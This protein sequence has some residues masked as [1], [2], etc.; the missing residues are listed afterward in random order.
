M[1]RNI[2]ILN[3]KVQLN[4][5][6]IGGMGMMKYMQRL[7]KSL[8]LPV[9]VMP[10]AALLK[11]IGYWI[12]PTGWGSN[13]AIAAF[14]I[15]S[16]GAI[17]DNLPILFAVGIAIGMSQERELTV[18]LS[19][20]VSYMI[21]SR[22][23]SP[24]A[25]ALI[26][27]IP[28]AE[29]SAAF[30]NSANAFVGI[31]SGL[32]VAYNYKK[33]SKVKLPDAL[34]FFGGKRFVPI[35]STASMLVISLLLLIVW[36]F[37]YECFVSFGEM[38]S[39]LGPVGAGLYGFFNRLLIPT[40]LH[41]ALNSVFWFDVAGIND[42][43]KFWGT[44]SGGIKGVTGMYQ[45]GFFPVM[46]FGLPAAAIAIYQSAR[47]ERKKQ[48][49]TIL[50]SAAF[51]SFVTGVTEPLEFSFMF[52][53]P[54]L[55]F[56][57]ALLTGIMLFVAAVF[58]WLAGFGFSAGLIDYILSIKAPFSNDIFMLIPLGLICAFI[59]YCI[60]RFMIVRYTLMTP[61]RET[62]EDIIEIEEEEYN[63][64]LENQDYDEI[65]I[66]L[67]EALGGRNNVQFADSCI[68][69]LRVELGNPD[70]VDEQAILATGATGII[71]IGKNNLQ[72]IIG[73]EVQFIVDAMNDILM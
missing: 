18:A 51:A 59:Y 57:H 53:A 67:I 21:V 70:L 16:G 69:R 48:V 4:P 24:P 46:M 22:L 13:N 65:A 34:S 9:S 12:D 63:I 45:A 60:F 38:I 28:E 44:V 43:G 25:V 64:T 41:H 54:V 27:G 40:G 23:L 49:G 56:I 17:I 30:E 33:F 68:T 14:L 61:G 36:P 39:K 35:I 7:G 6:L 66:V 47:P 62:D 32:V 1:F 72:I 52:V 71:K 29:V 50:L 31:I 5:I 15:E 55:Y 20:V 19:A 73:T 3:G 8:M 37:F 26:K 2:N 11:G 58:K 42:I 10:I